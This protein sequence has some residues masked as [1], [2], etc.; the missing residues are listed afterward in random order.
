MFFWYWDQRIDELLKYLDRA[1]QDGDFIPFLPRQTHLLLSIITNI[2]TPLCHYKHSF[3]YPEPKA[4]SLS[5]FTDHPT[6]AHEAIKKQNDIFKR[7]PIKTML[8]GHQ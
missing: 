7:E 1:S 6:S 5:W 8:L 4:C 2:P 3:L